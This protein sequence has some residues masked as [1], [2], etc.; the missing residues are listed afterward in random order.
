MFT[1][2]SF[3]NARFTLGHV[4]LFMAITLS[5]AFYH[6]YKNDRWLFGPSSPWMRDPSCVRHWQAGQLASLM[7]YRPAC[8]L[9]VRPQLLILVT[10]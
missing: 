8:H 2:C 7:T 9:F 3:C 6:S 10:D 1:L 5:P 4:P